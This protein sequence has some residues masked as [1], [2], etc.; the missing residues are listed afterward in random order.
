MDESLKRRKVLGILLLG[1]DPQIDFHSGGIGLPT[2]KSA[3]HRIA[4]FMGLW[5]ARPFHHHEMGVV[6]L[7][8]RLLV[9]EHRG[10]TPPGKIEPR[11]RIQRI[12]IVG[13]A[14]F[15]HSRRNAA[16]LIRSLGT[17]SIKNDPLAVGTFDKFSDDLA[18]V[19]EFIH[20]NIDGTLYRDKMFAGII[21]VVPR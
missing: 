3:L 21:E 8:E 16:V 1:P 11:L 4:Y 10:G 15:V 19:R 9:L 5:I 17:E 7:V 18:T 12:S 13:V 20:L 14:M 2:G 6:V